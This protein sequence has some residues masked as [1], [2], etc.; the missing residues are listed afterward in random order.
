MVQ[1]V[2]SALKALRN[3]LKDQQMRYCEPPLNLLIESSSPRPSHPMRWDLYLKQLSRRMLAYQHFGALGNI[4]AED[5]IKA[6]IS[7]QHNIPV[8]SRYALPS[9]PLIQSGQR[10]LGDVCN[11]WHG[12]QGIS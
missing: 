9:P 12:S 2:E 5:M 10:M 1:T 3:C 7:Q 6:V 4:L 8:L 11:V